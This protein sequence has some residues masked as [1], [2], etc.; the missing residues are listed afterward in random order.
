MDRFSKE[1]KRIS[2]RFSLCTSIEIIVVLPDFL[3]CWRLC[4]KDIAA[5]F[6]LLQQHSTVCSKKEK[7]IP[8]IRFKNLQKIPLYPY[9]INST[10]IYLVCT[11][12]LSS[13]SNIGESDDKSSHLG[14][15]GRHY[16]PAIELSFRIFSYKKKKSSIKNI[17]R[18]KKSY[19]NE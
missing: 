13:N 14:I 16:I 9:G 3:H 6:L 7:I 19:K 10:P 17:R 1:L 8:L 4:S 2:H 5:I 12:H 18:K 15:F 11:V